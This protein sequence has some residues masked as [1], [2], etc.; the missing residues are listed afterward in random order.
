MKKIFYVLIILALLFTFLGCA[1]TKAKEKT[2]P[3]TTKPT[4]AP[5][6][7]P[8]IIEHKTS[9]FG[10]DVPDWVDMTSSELEALP[11]YEGFYVFVED[12]SGQSR[13]GIEMWAREFSAADALASFI[14]TK[15]QSKFVGAAA[16]D[17]DFI[18][19]YMEQV[20]KNMSQGEFSGFREEEKFWVRKRYFDQDG[21]VDHEEYRYLFLFTIP[22]KELSDAVKRA[23]D[24]TKP[25]TEEEKSA[26]D[27]VLEAWGDSFED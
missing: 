10:G 9:D 3:T 22:K 8:Q 24:G 11:K 15:V 26:K 16:G 19:T 5:P 27:R 23:Y 7:P 25:E 13:E 21:N 14:K 6:P 4:P 20:V 18:E 1:S 2:E 17:K 12:H